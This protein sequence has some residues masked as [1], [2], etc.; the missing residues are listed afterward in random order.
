MDL[1]DEEDDLPFALGDF[2]DDGLQTLLELTLVLRPSDEGTHVEGIDLLGAK[3]LRDVSTD[4]TIGETLGDSSLPHTGFTDEDW[5][6]LRP[7]RKD[8]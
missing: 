7:T 6:I 3:V 4:N 2:A 1:V 5:V 8:L